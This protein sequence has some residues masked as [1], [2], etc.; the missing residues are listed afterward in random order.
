VGFRAIFSCLVPRVGLV[1]VERNRPDNGQRS[2]ISQPLL[3]E[4]RTLSSDKSTKRVRN[5]IRTSPPLIQTEQQES[6]KKK[7]TGRFNAKIDRETKS[8]LASAAESLSLS[9]A[10]GR[11][12]EKK[13]RRGTSPPPSPR[14]N[15]CE[16]EGALRRFDH[17]SRR[18]RTGGHRVAPVL[19]RKG[20][21]RALLSLCEGSSQERIEVSEA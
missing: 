19:L 15:S 4:G 21:F 18:D 12:E 3:S 11:K 5:P 8:P 17:F 20:F 6:K 16:R 2:L 14:E 1:A 7:T 13:N 10:R 9:L